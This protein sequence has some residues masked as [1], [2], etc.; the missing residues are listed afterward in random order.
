MTLRNKRYEVRVGFGI[1]DLN[2]DC[3]SNCIHRGKKTNNKL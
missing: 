2:R 3:S 1:K